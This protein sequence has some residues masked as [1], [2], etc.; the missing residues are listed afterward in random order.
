MIS[1]AGKMSRRITRTGFQNA[2]AHKFVTALFSQTLSTLLNP[3]LPPE[4]HNTAR[5]FFL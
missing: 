1:D 5:N 3:A 2:E 4:Y